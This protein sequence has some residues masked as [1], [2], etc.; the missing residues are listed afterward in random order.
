M[1]ALV[2]RPKMS[3]AM[4]AAL[5]NH[6]MRQREKKKQEQEADAATERVRREQEQKRRQD[7][8]TLE[9]IKD[10]VQQ[11]EQRLHNL[12]EEKHQLFMQLKKVLHEDDTRRRALMK[13]ANEMAALNHQQYLQQTAALSHAAAAAAAASAPQHIYIQEMNRGHPMYKL[14]QPMPQ[15]AAVLQRAQLKR[16]L[17]PSPPPPQQQQQQPPPPSFPQQYAYKAQM[18]SYGGPKLIPAYAAA[19]H[20]PI[21]YAHVPGQ[22]SVPTMAP[23]APVPYPAYPTAQFPHHHPDAAA[24]AAAAAAA[25]V[26][27]Q[28]Q[29]IVATHSFHMTPQGAYPGPV[30]AQQ[31]EH[32]LQ[33]PRFHEEKFYVS[34]PSMIPMRTMTSSAQSA[35]AMAAQQQQQQQQ[36]Q[37]KAAYL[38][39][40]QQLAQR[41]PGY[42]GQPT[43][44]Y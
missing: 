11:S 32:G 43:R 7:A 44:F 35:M 30:V 8:M 38:T 21:Y 24:A 4:W 31:L 34:Q 26:K 22:S 1:P 3:L 18:P 37:S 2:E 33:K 16:P 42:P 23:A 13:E 9:E 10:Q 20:G 12:K 41:H 39:P 6:I 36:Q 25:V 40:Q 15:S 28:Q 19:G 17:S 27:Q 29:H 14:A 5:K